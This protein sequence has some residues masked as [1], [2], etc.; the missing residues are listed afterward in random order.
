MKVGARQLHEIDTHQTD[1]DHPAGHTRHGDAVTDTHTV[2]SDEEEIRHDRENHVLQRHGDTGGDESD[3]GGDGADL[4]HQPEYRYERK[5]YC[6]DDSAQHEKLAPATQIVEIAESRPP[7]DVGD[8]QH[9]GAPP[10]HD[11]Q[12]YRQ[13]ARHA[14][15]PVLEGIAPVL[16]C[17]HS[18]VAG[19]GLLAQR[20]EHGG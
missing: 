13:V 7:P 12:A 17:A 4:R 1:I 9:D 19:E 15:H 18:A 2:A 10:E 8:N 3:I 11:P 14:G 6:H 16:Q 5:S 20:H